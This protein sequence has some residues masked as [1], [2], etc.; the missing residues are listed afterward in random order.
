MWIGLEKLARASFTTLTMPACEQLQHLR[1]QW[2]DPLV[3]IDAPGL[4][5]RAEYHK[6]LSRNIDASVT[7][8][9]DVLY[10]IIPHPKKEISTAL[11]LRSPSGLY[12]HFHYQSNGPHQAGRSQS[13]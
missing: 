6:A 2:N 8:V 11:P 1:S 7:F 12:H 13:R 5:S 10:P 4:H 9:Y 3:T